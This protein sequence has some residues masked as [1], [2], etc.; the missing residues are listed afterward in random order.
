M[1]RTGRPDEGISRRELLRWGCVG[2][3]G[4][5]AVG[6]AAASQS[7]P[8]IALEREGRGSISSGRWAYEVAFSSMQIVPTDAETIRFGG[9]AGRSMRVR[10]TDTGKSATFEPATDGQIYDAQS[11]DV[12]NLHLASIDTIADA[13]PVTVETA[14]TTGPTDVAGEWRGDRDIYKERPFATYVVE[15]LDDS[16][17]VL[18]TTNSLYNPSYYTW[19]ADLS[20]DTARITRHDGVRE[21]WNVQFTIVDDVSDF[22]RTDTEPSALV[23]NNAGDDYFTID[24]SQFEADLT[25]SRWALKMWDGG[26]E[27]YPDYVFRISGDGSVGAIEETDVCD[28]DSLFCDAFS[29]GDYSTKWTTRLDEGDF[30]ASVT[31]TSTAPLGGENVLELSETTGGGTNGVLGW[32]ETQSGWGEPWTMRGSF[33]TANIG[34]GAPFTSHRLLLYYD[35]EGKAAPVMLRLGFRQ[36]DGSVVPFEFDGSRVT[37][38]TEYA[39]SDG[40]EREAWYDYE[41]SY[42]GSGAL[43][44]RL[45]QDAGG[46]GRPDRPDIT[47]TVEPFED[48]ERVAA[49]RFNGPASYQIDGEFTTQH[50]F[51]RWSGDGSVEAGPDIYPES[52]DISP[53][54]VETG[55]EP[56]VGVNIANADSATLTASYEDGSG[57]VV[58]VEREMTTDAD[59][60][61]DD[62]VQWETQSPLPAI[63]APGTWVDLSFEA[64]TEDGGRTT[65]DTFEGDRRE[66]NDDIGYHVFEHVMSAVVI[67]GRFADSDAL[68]QRELEDVLAW[69]KARQ[70]DIN[71]YFGSSHGAMGAVGFDLTFERAGDDLYE[72]PETAT[73]YRED[74]QSE[75]EGNLK[76]YLRDLNNEAADVDVDEYDFWVGTHR[77]ESFHSKKG[78]VYFPIG[79]AYIPHLT[80]RDELYVW[81]HELSHAYGLKHLYTLGM[82]DGL[83]LL[84]NQSR[85]STVS[86]LGEPSLSTAPRLAPE[87]GLT[88]DFQY[89][90]SDEL[91]NFLTPDVIRFSETSDGQSATIPALNSLEY[92]ETVPIIRNHRSVESDA[93]YVMES[94][95]HLGEARND[96]SVFRTWEGPNEPNPA[97]HGGAVVYKRNQKSLTKGGYNVVENRNA[98]TPKTILLEEGDVLTDK[99]GLVNPTQVEFRLDW[100][101]DGTT[102]ADFSTFLNI[103]QATEDSGFITVGLRTLGDGVE[104]GPELLSEGGEAFRDGVEE[105]GD[106]VDDFVDDPVESTGEAVDGVVEGTGKAVNNGVDTVGDAT[107]LWHSEESLTVPSLHLVAEDADGNRVGPAEDGTYEA[108]IQGAS[109]SGARVGGDEWI[110][111]PADAD[112]TFSVD[113]SAVEQ[114]I[115]ELVEIGLASDDPGEGQVS[116][117]DLRERFTTSYDVSETHY[118]E[119]PELT[120]RNGQPWVTDTNVRVQRDSIEPGTQADAEPSNAKGAIDLVSI[121]ADANLPEEQVTFENRSDD[122]LAVGGWTVT[123]LDG[124]SYSFP[125]GTSIAAGET[126]TLYSHS[127][128]DGDGELFWGADEAVWNP[129]GGTLEV[130]D[131]DGETK[132]D[133]GYD[134]NGVIYYDPADVAAGSGGGFPMVLAGLGAVSAGMLYLAARLRSGDEE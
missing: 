98:E 5:Y 42:D 73:A 113:S 10:N 23:E 43:T 99:V 130:T 32:S 7:V 96:S 34:E 87:L 79:R 91:E 108:E 63:D 25:N 61:G 40:W 67:E 118:G 31:T 129:D 119:N 9:D 117:D 18:A 94:R 54:P 93:I 64:E 78:G 53:G 76:R 50:A 128:S 17:S 57:D 55:D 12:P 111:V 80:D 30:T 88:N 125:D 8:D 59:T 81:L 110:S 49:L 105:G 97:Q 106:T 13:E 28:V 107:G 123:A 100:K 66:E 29:D 68:S 132:L 92:D 14:S 82:D 69:E 60:S 131:T 112:V 103:D 115:Q 104:E 95:A 16:G 120:T 21:D 89:Q 124:D 27:T 38:T 15:L 74:W 65:A 46:E 133:V 37:E 126:L 24:A 72:L 102:P 2:T 116:T 101:S 48:A 134:A 41:V 83:C 11:I 85:S 20:G 47:A 70:Y 71:H 127:G 109:T 84:G 122:E 90:K 114:R 36:G 45:W 6:G 77:G 4:T 26:M 44:G 56:T 121:R 86:N 51:L 3:V 33:Y 1:E 19:R 62:A 75:F 22:E 35:G 39:P 52:I 58:E